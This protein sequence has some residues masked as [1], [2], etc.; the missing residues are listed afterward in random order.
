MDNIDK[1][2]SPNTISDE[3]KAI[4]AEFKPSLRELIKA[5]DFGPGDFRFNKN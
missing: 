4:L 2:Y 3:A 5:P 1:F